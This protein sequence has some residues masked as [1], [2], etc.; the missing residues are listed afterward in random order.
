MPTRKRKKRAPRPTGNPWDRLPELPHLA[1]D[2]RAR[3]ELRRRHRA[4]RYGLFRLKTAVDQEQDIA[5]ASADLPP[6]F[7]D[8]WRNGAWDS[9]CPV[10]LTCGAG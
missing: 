10:A 8:F 9:S 1:G 6:G 4:V 2:Q 5:K 7:A 3:M